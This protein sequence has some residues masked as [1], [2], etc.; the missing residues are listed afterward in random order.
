MAI[1]DTLPHPAPEA[2]DARRIFASCIAIGVLASFVG[3][4]AGMVAIGEGWGAA[5]GLGAFVGF[6]GGLGFGAMVGGVIW[7]TRAERA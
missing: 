1:I 3:V 7:A 6:W 4:T 2:T 5:V